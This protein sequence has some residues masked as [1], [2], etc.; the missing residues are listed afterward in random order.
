VSNDLPTAARIVQKF[1]PQVKTVI[2][3][4]QG[5]VISVTEEDCEKGKSREPHACAMARAA[6]RKHDGAVISITIAYLVDGTQAKRY[7]VPRSLSRELVAFDR[8]KYF[9][10]GD[11]E[12]SAPGPGHKLGRRK[13]FKPNL[14]KSKKRRMTR[15]IT[16]GVRTLWE[17]P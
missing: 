2:D 7:F 14:G 3:A 6:M 13:V 17:T 10:P 5:V 4:K 1:F 16:S 11:Y 12:L 15:H 9:S 8:A